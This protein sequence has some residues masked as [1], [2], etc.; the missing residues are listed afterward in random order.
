MQAILIRPP[1]GGDTLARLAASFT[2]DC[3]P[4]RV[5]AESRVDPGARFP[6]WDELSGFFSTGIRTTEIRDESGRDP[7]LPFVNLLVTRLIKLTEIKFE[8]I[9]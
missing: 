1:L 3:A 2:C 4:L 5:A 8:P 9:R 7:N 6:K